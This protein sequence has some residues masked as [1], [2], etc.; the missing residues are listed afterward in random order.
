M[1]YDYEFLY[2][3]RCTLINL[4][5]RAF[6]GVSMIAHSV[7][8]ELILY[9]CNEETKAFLELIPVPEETWGEDDNEDWV[10]DLF[11]DADIET[12]L[13]SD[14]YLDEKHSYH[15]SHWGEM[16]FYTN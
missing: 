13:F 9:L 7:L 5:R 16:Q 3:M 8:E 10:F 15:F 1:N 6:A 2:Q 14:L 12:Y 11:D 4:I